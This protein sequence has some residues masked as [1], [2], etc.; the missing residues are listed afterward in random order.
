MR[1]GCVVDKAC[2]MTECSTVVSTTATKQDRHYLV[3]HQTNKKHVFV[4]ER[5]TATHVLSTVNACR[6]QNPHLYIR[7]YL[8]PLAPGRRLSDLVWRMGLPRMPLSPSMVSPPN[9]VATTFAR[10]L[11]AGGPMNRAYSQLSVSLLRPGPGF[12]VPPDLGDKFLLVFEVFV[13]VVVPLPL[14]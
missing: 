12:L 10:F 9:V 11:L 5:S 2:V 1:D 13:F 8:F 6:S 7:S 3:R 14:A 4:F